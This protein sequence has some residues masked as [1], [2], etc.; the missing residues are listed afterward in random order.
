MEVCYNN[1]WGLISD[2]G[3]TDGDA[4]VVCN[5]LGYNGRGIVLALIVNPH[6]VGMET[7]NT[8]CPCVCP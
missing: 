2:L 7:Y 4:R 6:H 1:L 8:V 3:W 5:N